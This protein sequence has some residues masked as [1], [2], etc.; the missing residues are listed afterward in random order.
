MFFII[1]F[2]LLVT[3]NPS[4]EDPFSLRFSSFSP[5]YISFLCSLMV[6]VCWVWRVA[7]TAYNSI[8]LCDISSSFL[9]TGCHGSSSHEKRY[10]SPYSL[11][12]P[13]SIICSISTLQ[14]LIKGMMVVIILILV[15][16]MLDNHSPSQLI[17]MNCWIIESNYIAKYWSR[18]INLSIKTCW[19]MECRFIGC[20]IM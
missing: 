20:Q 8:S 6:M 4:L 5:T 15:Q 11:F 13:F 9:I 18:P 12:L 10:F 1:Y 2:L 7:P 3:L 14:Q 17:I 19:I 16:W